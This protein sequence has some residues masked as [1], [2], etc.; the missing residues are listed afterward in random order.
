MNMM[1]ALPTALVPVSRATPDLP[2]HDLRWERR[3]GLLFLAV[4]V[5][6]F[7]VWSLSARFDAAVSAKGVV[8][9]A[10]H[11]QTVQSAGPGVISALRVHEGDKVEAGQPLLDLAA[12]EAL[13][14]ERSLAARVF[15]LQAQV[16]RALA[17]RDGQGSIARP[18]EWA[19]L[20]PEDRALAERALADEQATL[21]ADRGVLASQQ[22]VLR[23]RIAQ[24]GMQI[25]GFRDRQISN[26]RQN[27]INQQELSATQKLFEKGYASRTRLLA[28]QR[29]DAALQGEIGATSAEMARLH[30]TAGEARIQIGQLSQTSRQTAADKLAAAQS[31]L[32][33]LQPQW[34]A[35]REQLEHNRLRAPVA[36]TVQNLTANTLGGVVGTGQRLMDIVP[37]RQALVVEAQIPLT[38][39]NELRPGKRALVHIDGLRGRSLPAL[40]GTVTRISADSIVDEKS[41]RAYYLATIEVSAE[42]FRRLTQAAGLQEAIRPGTQTRVTIPLRPRSALLYWLEPLTTRFAGAFSAG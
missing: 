22:A 28:L 38:D 11:S 7:L 6:G 41:G 3:A 15:S 19:T 36:G 12:S 35:A 13:G 23:Q 17:E 18:A 2:V 5:L 20:S 40:E 1:T 25:Q 14:Q 42:Q 9:V 16:A 37:A 31:E 32:A 27:D 21:L 8:R 24:A 26:Q 4:F 29:N 10:G 33:S 39:A 30:A 34:Q